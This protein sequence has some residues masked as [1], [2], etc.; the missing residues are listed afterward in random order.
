MSDRATTYDESGMTYRLVSTEKQLNELCIELENAKVIAVDTETE[1]LAYTDIIVGIALSARPDTSYYIPIRHEAIDGVLYDGQLSPETVFGKLKP[2][3]ET[4]PCT[5]HNTPFDIKMFWKDGIDVNYM[6][7]TLI[8]AHLLGIDIRSKGL[9]SLV[10]HFFNHEMPELDSLFPKI[11][12][13][14]QPILPKI[15]S[16]EDIRFYGCEDG[17]WSLQLFIKLLI[18]IKQ[19]SSLDFTHQL[20]MKLVK[21]VAEMESFGVPTSLEFLQEN[22]QQA[23]FYINKLEDH[24]IS[25][26]RY[27]LDDPEFAINLASPKQLGDLLFNK[28]GLPPIAFSKKTGNPS[29]DA[30]TL[31]ALAPINPIV[32]SILTYRKLKKLDDTYLGGLQDKV[33]IDGRIRG[34]FI[35]TGTASGRFSSKN[36]NLQNLPKDQIF[37]LWKMEDEDIDAVA[38]TF[39][40][41]NNRTL[42]WD[43]DTQLWRAYNPDID[44][45]GDF[46]LGVANNG[47]QYGVYQGEIYEMWQCK[48]RCFIETS[49]DHYLIDADYSQIELRIMAGESL[50]PT[51]LD[52]FTA[53]D[54]V[55]KKT[56]GV[57]FNTPF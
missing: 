50:E 3:L 37:A 45:W 39:E 56:A 2:I 53:G 38:D 4:K 31:E 21:V 43:A 48:T 47:K 44:I 33:G 17:N 36:P 54:D 49:D 41:Y 57:I 5:G 9:K 19:R 1:G 11:G 7:D 24:I 40:D 34:S 55:H 16:P 30:D 52:A 8:M 12:N 26:I 46:F 18:M 6:Y 25:T 13:K 15:L 35:Q 42:R 10:K 14:K 23:Q 29:T 27:E 20:E 32:N 51:L 22:S 28:L